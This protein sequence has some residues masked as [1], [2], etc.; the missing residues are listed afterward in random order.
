MDDD[1][2]EAMVSRD[3]MGDYKKGTMVPRIGFA[4]CLRSHI[5]D[6]Y[7]KARTSQSKEAPNMERCL[8]LSNEGDD[9]EA[10][11]IPYS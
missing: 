5:G 8:I 3:W 9:T 7:T 1:K 4:M 2:E 10:H 11:P 6:R